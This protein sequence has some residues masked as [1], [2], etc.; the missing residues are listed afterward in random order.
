MVHGRLLFG[1]FPFSWN[2]TFRFCL[3]IG[4]L[5][6]AYLIN[7]ILS[8][9]L[10]QSQRLSLIAIRIHC[11]FVNRCLAVCFHLVGFCMYIMVQE[12]WLGLSQPICIG[13]VDLSL[14]SKEWRSKHDLRLQ[15]L[16]V[17]CTRFLFSLSLCGQVPYFWPVSRVTKCYFMPCTVTVMYI[18]SISWMFASAIPLH[19][20]VS[21]ST[22]WA[23]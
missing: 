13:A 4:N 14:H 19:R 20:V 3:R 23:T 21:G 16:R 8:S 10:V 7:G 2:S 15:C 9:G 1:Y 11:L 6:H 12:E 17:S 22:G 5:W 18:R